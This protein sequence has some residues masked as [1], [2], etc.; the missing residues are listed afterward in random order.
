[1][2]YKANHFF[3]VRMKT[4]LLKI[5]LFVSGGLLALGARAQSSPDSIDAFLQDRMQKLHIP[6]LQVAIIRHGKLAKLSSYGS[7]NVEHAV[8]TTN[9]SVFSVNSIT[10][11][12]VGVAVMQLV[13]AGKLR[14]DDPLSRYL[15]DLPSTWQAVT[16]KQVLT[17]TSGLPNIIDQYEHV[18]AD[19]REAAAWEKVKTL[20]LESQPGEKFSYNQTGYVMLGKIITQ[21]S[22]VHFTKFI[23]DGQF[24]AA[25]LTQTR[26]GDSQD[27]IPHSAG[28]Y[29]TK[30]NIEGQWVDRG[31]LSAAY[32]EFPVFFRT[33]TGILSTA[34]DM[35]HWLLALQD[36][37]LLKDKASLRTL[38]TPAVLNNGQVGGFND[39]VNGYALGWPTVTRAE[40]PAVGPV[41]GMRSAFFV[42]PQD[43]LAIIVL[44]NVQGAS[45]EYF[46]DEVAGYYLPDMKQSHGFGLSPAI[47]KLRAELLKQG[48]DK[49]PVIAT[50]LKKKDTSFKLAENDLNAWG[51]KLLEQ[52]QTAQAVA[53]F[54]LNVSLYPQS[55]NTYDSLAETLEGT[56]DRVGALKNY[57]RSL[58]LNPANTNAVAHIKVLEGG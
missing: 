26:F 45:P 52:K 37:R 42:Y 43:E 58:A 8:P 29:T 2:R 36:G 28:A 20:P 3:R 55:A 48:F 56:G 54:R 1:M 46:I 38:W 14:V 39:L 25:N 47:K 27:V 51:Y 41:G 24:K 32:A 9:E 5:I 6:G 15:P 11:A 12:F 35:A 49:A 17:N 44:S 21:V 18:L 10:K 50:R 40:H 57:R 34:Q 22:G 23:E 33:A 31:E 13:E 16:L 4:A 19:G 7:A 53:I 30:R